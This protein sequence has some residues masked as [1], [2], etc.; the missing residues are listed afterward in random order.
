MATAVCGWCG[1]STHV[2]EFSQGVESTNDSPDSPQFQ[3]AFRCDA[4]GGLLI[5]GFTGAEEPGGFNSYGVTD[6]TYMRSFWS[7]NKPTVWSPRFVKGQSFTDVPRHIAK[8]A[9]ES[10][11]SAS[12]GNHMSAI[13][14]ARTVIE[15]SA[16]EKGI[17]KGSLLNKI[18]ELAGKSLIREDTKEAAHAIREFGND[19]AHG[20]ISNPVS[21][22]DSEEVLVLM[23]EI[24]NELF[25]G[26]A[27]VQAIKA[28]VAARKAN[29]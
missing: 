2:T 4:C 28:K 3:S 26:P 1:T 21:E 14:M 8:A 24:L 19:M 18:D 10:Y 17:L 29:P 22:E 6:I 12:I 15:A 23:S 5:G 27:R 7:R 16:K 20:D 9:S 25:Q 13:L 11:K